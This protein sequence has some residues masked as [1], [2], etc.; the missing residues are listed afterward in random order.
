MIPY[1]FIKWM[2][3][4]SEEVWGLDGFLANLLRVNLLLDFKDGK[5]HTIPFSTEN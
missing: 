4:D 1:Y 3:F 5:D 2:E